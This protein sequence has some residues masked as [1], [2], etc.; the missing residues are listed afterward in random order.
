VFLAG[1]TLPIW[2]WAPWQTIHGVRYH[3]YQLGYFPN[4]PH[5]HPG[6]GLYIDTLP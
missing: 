2:Y 1:V 4:G 3:G 6:Y 5:G